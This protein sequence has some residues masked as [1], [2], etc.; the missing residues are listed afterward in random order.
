VGDGVLDKLARCPTPVRV[1]GDLCQER[2]VEV[3]VDT[4]CVSEQVPQGDRVGVRTS[5]D[6]MHSGNEVR[7]EVLRDRLVQGDGADLGEA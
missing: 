2:L 1:R 5:A 6:H 4:A 3:V 7:F